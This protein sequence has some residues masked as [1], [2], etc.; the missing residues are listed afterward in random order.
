MHKSI[1]SNLYVV[2]YEV[3]EG[4]VFFLAIFFRCC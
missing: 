2:D 1:I 3:V 4:R